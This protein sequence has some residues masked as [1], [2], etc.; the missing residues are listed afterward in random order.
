MRAVA[1]G[2][3]DGVHRGHLALL[4]RARALAAADGLTAGAVTFEPHPENVLSGKR[5]SRLT[6]PQRKA[7]LLR[8]VVDDLWVEPFT[9]E[10]AQESPREFARRL[11][12]G[13]LEARHVVVGDNFRFGHR[14]AGDVATLQEL[15]AELGFEVHPISMQSE[16][17][18]P[19]SSS[20]ARAALLDGRPEEASTVLGRYHAMFGEVVHG[21]A[22]GRTLGVPTCN[23]VQSAEMFPGRGIYAVFVGKGG[24]TG[25]IQTFA[26]GVASVGTRPTIDPQQTRESVEVHL[27]DVNEDLYGQILGVAFVQKLRNEERYDS[28]EA[29]TTQMRLDLEH[30]RAALVHAP[31]SQVT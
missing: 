4:E 1:I 19:L 25:V 3:F 23:I 16:G 27:F 24:P 28:L 11:L 30:A 20:R 13:R 18:I 26:R 10:L 22:R 7:T 6:G 17:G 29:L 14:R 21:D 31:L 2:N 8:L 9:P 12:A 15:G 5:M